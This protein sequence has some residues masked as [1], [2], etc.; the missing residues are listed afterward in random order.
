MLSALLIIAAIFA[1]FTFAMGQFNDW[2]SGT[3]RL[4]DVAPSNTTHL[5]GGLVR[6]KDCEA[7]HQQFGYTCRNTP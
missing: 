7:Y 5:E 4:E 2:T 3:P 1:G 6:R